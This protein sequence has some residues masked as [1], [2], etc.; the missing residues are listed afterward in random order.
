[1]T[2][3]TPAKHARATVEV[4]GSAKAPFAGMHHVSLTIGAFKA[5]ASYDDSATSVTVA[6]ALAA[7]ANVWGSPVKATATG[8]FV[9]LTTLVAGASANM[10]YTAT[11]NKDFVIGPSTGA[12]TGGANAMTTTKYDGGTIDVAVGTVTASSN[13]GKASTPQSIAGA[14]AVSLNTAGNG[15]FTATAKG[16]TIIILP[17]TK[18]PTSLDVSVNVN[19]AKGFTPPSFTATSKN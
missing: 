11:N 3:T 8:N 17:S 4:T 12:L 5:T 18:A 6:K 10:T 7:A 9:T 15:A 16:N 1:M 19:D 14:L 2:V 13:W